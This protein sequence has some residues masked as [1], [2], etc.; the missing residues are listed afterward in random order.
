M[1]IAYLG[2]G[3]NLGDRIG[4]LKEATRMIGESA[5]K[6]IAV[7]SVYETEPV[8]VEKGGDFLNMVVCV[9]TDL[10]PSGLL[11]RILMI[12]S[13]LGRIRCETRYS[14]RTIDIDILFYN[15]EII[16][17]DSLSIPHPR[18]HLRKFVLIPINELAT[19]LVHPVLGKS[20]K[21][22]LDECPDTSKVT[23]F[24]K[25]EKIF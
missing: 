11:G 10:S 3:S 24:M 4:F 15:N 20:I 1:K 2:L 18:L 9:G 13:K 21:E 25:P 6:I 16:E 8:E 12:E 14:S 7:S 22:L 19:G 17:N 23:L 5:G